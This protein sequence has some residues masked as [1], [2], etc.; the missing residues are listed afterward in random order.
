MDRE[1]IQRLIETGLPGARALVDGD[2]GVHF[3][4]TVIAVDFVGKSQLARHRMVY[5][6]LGADI[7]GAIHALALQTLS[8]DEYSARG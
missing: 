2:D 1:T 6:T 5:Q 4:A 8:P 7:G 3:K